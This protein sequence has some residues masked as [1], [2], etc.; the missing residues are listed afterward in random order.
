MRIVTGKEKFSQVTV[1]LKNTVFVEKPLFM[2]YKIP[3][4]L[5]I[6]VSMLYSTSALSALNH[7]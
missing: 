7:Q 6:L 2:D 5:L 1:R 4:F 3:V